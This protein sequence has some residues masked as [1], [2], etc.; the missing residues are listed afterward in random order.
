M[1]LCPTFS[2]SYFAISWVFSA[3]LVR[4]FVGVPRITSYL[5][6]PRFPSKPTMSFSDNPFMGFSCKRQKLTS[7]Q[8]AP[9]TEET[10][11]DITATS[12]KEGHG[13]DRGTNDNFTSGPSTC[14]SAESSSPKSKKSPTKSP[15]KP[16]RKKSTDAQ[17]DDDEGKKSS[18]TNASGKTSQKASSTI[19]V[20]PAIDG[21]DGWIPKYED[22]QVVP[23]VSLNTRNGWRERFSGV[24]ETCFEE[25]RPCPHYQEAPL[26]LLILG[27]CLCLYA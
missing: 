3:F 15:T 22:G 16:R 23:F 24:C 11:K 25:G 1:T 14:N 9:R 19:L 10:E 20:P 6:T 4:G 12:G 17:D 5:S 21:F 2:R 8:T 26:K 18:P 27:W 7:T 13:P